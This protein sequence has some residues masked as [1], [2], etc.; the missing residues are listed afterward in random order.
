MPEIDSAAVPAA[1]DAASPDAFEPVA[2]ASLVTPPPAKNLVGDWILLSFSLVVVVLAATMSIR[3]Q[4]EVLI[5]GT[6]TALPELCNFRRV[7]GIDCPGCG[8]TRGFICLGHGDLLG[9]WQY[10]P[11]SLPFFALIASQIPFRAIQIWRVRR[12]LPPLQLGQWTYY[13]LVVLILF[14]LGQWITRILIQRWE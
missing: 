2:L 4:T 14:V 9:A 3:E 10:N 12:G 1:P 6:R 5:P 7:A 11:A 13:P 8:M